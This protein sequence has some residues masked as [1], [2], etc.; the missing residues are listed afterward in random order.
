MGAP[1]LLIV[2]LYLVGVVAVGAWFSRRQKT[3]KQY[4]TGGGNIPWWAVAASI[5]ATETSTV[6][7]ISIPGSAYSRGGNFTFLQ[8]A[9]GYILGRIIVSALFV[10]MYF[11]GE[12]LTVYQLLGT[13]F[14]SAVKGALAALFVC[15]RSV[16]DGIRL[17]LTA[18][19][20][21]FTYEAFTGGA[22]GD[23][24]WYGSIAGLG[25]IMIL[26]TLWG[27][28]EAVIWIE[29]GQLC[30]Y[31]FGAVAAA[32]V[33]IGEVPGGLS[34]A[35]DTAGAASKL[36]WFQWN[37]TFDRGAGY[38]FAAGLVGGC[39]LTMATHGTD[40]YL[41]Q[42]YLC[43]SKPS[44][45]ALALIS[46]GFVVFLQ[47]VLFLVIGILLYQFYRP[48]EMEGAATAP[49]PAFPFASKDDVFSTFITH[50]LPAGIGGLVVAAILAAALSSSL[51]SIAATTVNDLIAPFRKFRDDREALAVSR[52]LTVAAG[53]IQIAIA[54]LFTRTGSSALDQ[55]LAVAGLFNGPVL[56]VF[57]LGAF[58]KRAGRAA[59]ATGLAAGVAAAFYLWIDGTVF[60]A[61][62]TAGGA[63]ATFV[64]GTMAALAIQAPP[65]GPAP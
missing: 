45:A 48:F 38:T 62:Y 17:L 58:V 33:L 22:A 61:W 53:V 34:G 44:R 7:F 12:L 19:V 51:N 64:A 42:R 59:A 10:P 50:E 1:D 47:F 21:R 46:S 18:R 24:A 49:N 30:I 6:T 13:R 60:W 8:L 3:T 39:F 14:G 43:V 52:K 41:V 20:L 23:A 35:L 27:G 40:Q 9:I 36:T 2:V 55:V 65:A 26:F 29:V 54:F 32:I 15:M 5:V 25:L 31:I 28:M 4:F 16:G 57:L 37:A 56:G 11:R 63:G